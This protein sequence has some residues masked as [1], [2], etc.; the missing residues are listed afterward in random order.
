MAIPGER[1]E[2][3]RPR[4]FLRAGSAFSYSPAAGYNAPGAGQPG[5]SRAAAPGNKE[6]LW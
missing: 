3:G 4:A 5:L 1:R 6:S 2:E